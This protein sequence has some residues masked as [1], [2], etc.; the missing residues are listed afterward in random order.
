MTRATPATAAGAR[1]DRGSPTPRR[2]G[3]WLGPV[4]GS[5]WVV[6]VVLAVPGHLHHRSWTVHA[7]AWVA[8]VAVMAP[9]IA[10]NVRYAA[11]R[12]PRSARRGIAASVAA[13]W[14]LVWLAPG[15][16]VAV[17]GALLAGTTGLLTAV[18]LATVAAL[19]W[20]GTRVKRLGLARCDRRLAPP[21]DRRLGRRAARRHGVLLGRDCLLSCWPLMTLMTVAGHHPLVIA[22]CG[23]VAWYERRR[24]PHHDPGT[25]ETALAIGAIGATVL[26]AAAL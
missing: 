4:A 16:V 21:I 1:L 11:L 3:W 26:L 25:R 6:L 14:A 13:G 23:G 7:V 5:G 10:P 15:A 22:A 24:R 8:M 9:L 2:P 17:G 20:Q 19:S 18:A 12:S